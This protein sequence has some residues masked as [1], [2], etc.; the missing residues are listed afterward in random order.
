M[1]KKVYEM[2]IDAEDE[3]SGVFKISLVA[4]PA[5]EIDWVKLSKDKRK[6]D[7]KTMSEQKRIVVGPSLIPDLKIPRIDDATGEEYFITF[8]EKTIELASQLY[9]KRMLIHS[10]NVEHSE[11]VDGVSLVESWIIS[12]PKND[13]AAALGFD[14]PKGTWMTA[15]KIENDELWNEYI[16]TGAL[17]GISIEASLEHREIALAS[18]EEELAKQ[19]LA[20]LKEVVSQFLETITSIDSSYSGNTPDASGSLQDKK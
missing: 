20:E 6:V 4:D 17:R 15:L 5:L 16:S 11:D 8:P 18:Q 7:M 2:Y 3:T 14:L 19:K 13:K 9:L 10:A 12:D 1:E